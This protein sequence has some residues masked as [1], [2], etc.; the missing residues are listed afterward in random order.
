MIHIDDSQFVVSC[1]TLFGDAIYF[2]YLIDCDDECSL[3][4]HYL[5]IAKCDF[6]DVT[7]AIT[8]NTTHKI[9]F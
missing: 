3:F 7:S 5:T 4:A 2:E 1:E 6:G 9:M 8:S